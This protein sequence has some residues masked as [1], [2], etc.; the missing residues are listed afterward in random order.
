MTAP[1][2]EGAQGFIPSQR[3]VDSAHDQRLARFEELIRRRHQLLSVGAKAAESQVHSGVPIETNPEFV[4]AEQQFTLASS[5]LDS[6]TREY[7]DPDFS[8][9][10][11]TE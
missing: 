3:A 4:A 7:S 1:H 6:S 11:I 2:G 8:E 10:T 5:Q 9:D